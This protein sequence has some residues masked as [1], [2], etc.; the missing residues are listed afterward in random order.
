MRRIVAALA[1]LGL[2]GAGP[3]SADP[4]EPDGL[5]PGRYAL[6]LRVASTARVPLLRPDR[7]VATSLL[8]VEV[9]RSAGGWTQRPRA[10]DVRVRNSSVGVHTTIPPAFVDGLPEREYPLRMWGAPGELRY[11]ADLGVE[12][13][14]L[15]PAQDEGEL[16]TRPGH[17]SVADTDGDGEPGA[18]IELRVPVLGTARIFVVQRSHLVLQGRQTAPGRVEGTVEIRL[19]EQRALGAEPGFFHR[20]PTI[21]PDP[22]R[23]GFTLLR[24][25]DDAGCD[26]L[27]PARGQG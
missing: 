13:V 3:P 24:L 17:P 5:G 26:D 11:R 1:F 14:G 18:T 4:T 25:P 10:C 23:S 7:S 15:Q 21:R 12:T 2:L 27:A 9:E 6:E 19:L 22:E 16:P 20:T 8:L